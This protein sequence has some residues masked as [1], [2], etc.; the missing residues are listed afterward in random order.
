MRRDQLDFGAERKAIVRL[1]E[2]KLAMLIAEAL[3]PGRMRRFLARPRSR[4]AASS[5][6]C[7]RSSPTVPSASVSRPKA[8]KPRWSPASRAASSHAKP[9]RS[10]AQRRSWRTTGADNATASTRTSYGILQIVQAPIA[11]SE[12]SPSLERRL[13]SSYIWQ[14]IRF[15]Y[16]LDDAQSLARFVNS[17]S[18]ICAPIY[19][20]TDMYENVQ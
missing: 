11:P 16:G 4:R 2:D 20:P 13:D 18:V 3:L 1:S 5:R 7:C 17:K 12:A 10:V 15:A 19:I 9:R 14:L 8:A 6:V